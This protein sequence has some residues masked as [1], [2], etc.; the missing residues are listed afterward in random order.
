MSNVN[1]KAAEYMLPEG[2]IEENGTVYFCHEDDDKKKLC[3]ANRSNLWRKPVT[4]PA[5]VT[6]KLF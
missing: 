4:A 2:F 5:T 1:S 6:G 3:P